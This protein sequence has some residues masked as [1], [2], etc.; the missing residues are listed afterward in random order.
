[1]HDSSL[2]KASTSAP[3]TDQDLYMRM[4]ELE[5]ELEIL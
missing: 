3:L 4:K 1:M 2:G 5:S